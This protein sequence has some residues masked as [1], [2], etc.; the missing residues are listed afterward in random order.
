MTRTRV[1]IVAGFVLLAVL[2]AGVVLYRA[3]DGQPPADLTVAW[4]GSEGHPSCVYD[5]KDQTVRA[6][7][8]IEGDAGMGRN[9]TATVTAY[10]D[11]NTSVPV[12]SGTR[13][14]R[15]EGTVH[16]RILVP[17][18]VEKA[19]KVDIDGETACRREV[20]YGGDTQS[21]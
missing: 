10:A 11:E 4:G 8:T 9:V 19:P 20:Q 14:L 15:V 18:P 16:K 12:G 2:A 21:R 1:S 5:P 3:G 13:T 17:F 6:T 7:L